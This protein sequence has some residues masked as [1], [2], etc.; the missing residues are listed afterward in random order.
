MRPHYETP[1]DLA[2]ER[3]AIERFAPQLGLRP[4]KVPWR[5]HF[6]FALVDDDGRIRAVVE[7]KNRTNAVGKFPTY[8][9]SAEKYLNLYQWSS[10]GIPSYLLVQFLDGLYCHQVQE[11]PETY[12][13]CGRRDRNDDDDIEPVVKIP[14]DRFSL[15]DD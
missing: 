6:D 10:R 4:E 3:E 14:I 7:V 11:L 13:V 12:Y 8:M 2:R 15:V 5:Y 9:L 1:E